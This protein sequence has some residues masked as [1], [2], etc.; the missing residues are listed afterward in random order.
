M[1]LSDK[2]SLTVNLSIH[3]SSF[4]IHHSSLMGRAITVIVVRIIESILC[5]KKQTGECKNNS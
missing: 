4:I 3:H 5:P 1:N 2:F